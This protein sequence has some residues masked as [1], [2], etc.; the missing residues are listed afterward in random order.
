MAR[1]DPPSGHFN[2]RLPPGRHGLPR[3]FVAGNQRLRIVAATLRVLPQHR[4]SGTTIAHITREASV[5][6]SAF[7]S[8]FEGKE[9]CFLATYDAAAYWICQ[10]LERTVDA[11]AEWPARVRGGVT[12]VLRLLAENPDL[13]HLFAVEVTQAGPAARERQQL[14]MGKFAEAL[15]AG[16]P[17]EEGLPVEL[18]EMLLGGVLVTIGRYVDAGRTEH[19]PEATVEL[20]QYLLIPYLGSEETSRISEEAA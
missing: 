9:D 6:R 14:V 18:E 16:R 2:T 4:Y 11:S 15:R 20:V 8:Q 3:S 12:A 13:A 1:G 10:H 17:R 5:S 19:L 7:Y